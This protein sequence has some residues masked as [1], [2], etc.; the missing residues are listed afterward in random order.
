MSSVPNRSPCDAILKPMR[1]FDARAGPPQ[2]RCLYE[3]MPGNEASHGARTAH[4]LR[5]EAF[6][7]PAGGP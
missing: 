3:S 5:P 4:R 1:R 7:L 2:S 6:G